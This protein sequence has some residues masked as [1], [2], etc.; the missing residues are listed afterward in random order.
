[1]KNRTKTPS[2][3]GG[4]DSVLVHALRSGDRV[5]FNKIF[6]KYK[7][8]LHKTI[9]MVVRDN[10]VAKD[11]LQ[12]AF[13]KIFI[14]IKNG[15]YEDKGM[16]HYWI[17]RIAFNLA[18]DYFRKSKKIPVLTSD[19]SQ[20]LLNNIGLTDS[21]VEMD[22]VA[23]D[24]KREIHRLL[25]LLPEDQRKVLV[26]RHFQKMPFKEIADKLDVSL[27]TALGR[28]RYALIN[29]KKKFYE[30]GNKGRDFV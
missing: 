20:D 8:K 5:A 30:A 15:K 24:S 11:L 7:E 10:E 12:D 1:M 28:M 17:Q 16:F 6:N 22:M 29:L 27:N 13:V 4:E 26:M 18:I 23:Y 14:T 21:S 25:R 9:Y 3:G 19:D 2:V